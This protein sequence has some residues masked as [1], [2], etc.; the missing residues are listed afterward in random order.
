[1]PAHSAMVCIVVAR[2]P[3]SQSSSYAWQMMRA[4]VASAETCSSRGDS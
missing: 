1:M 2:E 3:G 4:G